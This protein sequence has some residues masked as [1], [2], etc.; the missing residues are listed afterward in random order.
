M[1]C[2][3]KMIFLKIWGN[4]NSLLFICN[5]CGLKRLNTLKKNKMFKAIQNQTKKKKNTRKTKIRWQHW[6]LKNNVHGVH[7]LSGNLLIFCFCF[8]NIFLCVFWG[9]DFILIQTK[10]SI[11]HM[12]FKCLESI[13]YTH[14]CFFYHTH[15]PW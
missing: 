2:V 4:K 14:L 8:H 7:K 11:N 1:W 12:P 15:I 6:S 10:Y 5:V 13:L 9:W 3:K